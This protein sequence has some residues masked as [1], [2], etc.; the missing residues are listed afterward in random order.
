MA[1][2]LIDQYQ[3]IFGT[4]T[5]NEATELQFD[6]RAFESS[7]CKI[8]FLQFVSGLLAKNVGPQ[9]K[10]GICPISCNVHVSVVTLAFIVRHDS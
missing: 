9:G 1:S 3:H 5:V 6:I 2:I 10:Q 4:T 8:S 7:N